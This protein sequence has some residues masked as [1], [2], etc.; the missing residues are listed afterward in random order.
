MLRSDGS[1]EENM[2]EK[3]ETKEQKLNEQLLKTRIEAKELKGLNKD[4]VSKL[5]R[6]KDK[7]LAD[8]NKE[9]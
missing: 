7:I 2:P 9:G 1:E 6:S 4:M 3:K 5:S 8:L